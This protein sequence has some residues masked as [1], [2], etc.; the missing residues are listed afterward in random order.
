MGLIKEWRHAWEAVW[1]PSAAGKR[2]LS[3]N[4]S[5]KYYYSI[6][7][8][9]FILYVVLG[10]IS[11]WNGVAVHSYLSNMLD[12]RAGYPA[13]FAYA[14][15]F[16]FVLGPI[17]LF[18]DSALYQIVGKY[19]LKEW[20]GDYSKTFTAVAFASTPAIFL[21][22]FSFAPYINGALL[23]LAGIWSLVVLVVTLS[24]QQ[25]VTRTT[26]IAGVLV[27]AVL[28]ILIFFV[29]A[30]MMLLVLVLPNTA[31]L[32]HVAGLTYPT[33]V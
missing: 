1:H 19:F 27:T 6:A 24:E 32:N 20:K 26:A 2:K 33:I 13:L 21:A 5:L 7:I 4:G 31:M 14:I 16:F 29:V 8:V 23:L 9:G 18:I 11:I 28:V 22:W 25:K 17:G 10:A 12:V 30:W 15:L 3:I